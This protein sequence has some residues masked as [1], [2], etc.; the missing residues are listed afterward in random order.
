MVSRIGWNLC[1]L[2]VFGLQSLGA[3]DH[4]ELH[5]L[6]F[7]QAAEAVGLDRGMMDEDVVSILPA[8]ETKA[9][10][11]VK[12]FYCTFFHVVIL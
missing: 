4:L 9:F 6:A 5:G 2:D 1:Q 3:G 11:V 8:D 12:P 10:S 7:L